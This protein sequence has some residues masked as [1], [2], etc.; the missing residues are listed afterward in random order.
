MGW[1]SSM[2]D[3]RFTTNNIMDIR[4]PSINFL[5]RDDLLENVPIEPQ[6]FFSLIDTCLVPFHQTPAVALYGEYFIVYNPQSSFF[7]Y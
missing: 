1:V 2:E 4:P 5:Q 6:V 3:L 7:E